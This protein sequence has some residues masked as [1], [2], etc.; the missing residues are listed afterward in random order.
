M[1]ILLTGISGQVG[2]ALR[3]QLL[4]FGEVIAADRARLDLAAPAAIPSRLD[5]LAPDLIINPAA[6]TAVDQAERDLAVAMI[7]NAEAPSAIAQWAARRHVPLLHFSTDYVFN[8]SGTRPWREDDAVG[9]LSAYGTSKLAGEQAIRDAGGP[10]LILRTSWVYA[11]TGRN[12]LTT[13]ARLA[14]EREELRVVADQV[15]APTSAAMIAATATQILGKATGQQICERFAAAQGLLH[16]CAA[17][18]TSWHG[19]ASDILAGLQ[20]RGVRLA[21]QR[22]TA[23]STADYPTA[24][25]RPANSRLDCERLAQVLAIRLPEWRIGL[26]AEL[27]AVAMRA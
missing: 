27:D 1:R 13:I 11:A 25:R 3:Q 5:A 24:A 21:C 18:E 17:G 23:I 6:Y 20:Q 14:H 10:H 22:V 7:V 26:D 12:F 2:G 8:G 19:F 9:P 4:C 16:L 15:G